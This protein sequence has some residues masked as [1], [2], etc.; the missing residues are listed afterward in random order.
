MV[1]PWIALAAMAM[2]T[3]RIRLGTSVTPPSAL[4]AGARDGEP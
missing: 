4:E 1:D 2:K 3:E